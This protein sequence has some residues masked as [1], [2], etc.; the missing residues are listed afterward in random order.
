M[1]VLSCAIFVALALIPKA[2]CQDIKEDMTKVN[3]MFVIHA[4][5]PMQIEKDT[6][7]TLKLTNLELLG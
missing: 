7:S 3:P 5:Q 1:T 2:S 6:T 4:E